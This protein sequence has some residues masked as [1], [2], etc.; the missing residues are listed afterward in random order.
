MST[1]TAERTVSARTHAWTHLSLVDVVC[2]V[3]TAAMLVSFVL[4][5]WLIEASASITGLSLLLSG[6]PPMTAE[7]S[8]AQ[9]EIRWALLL[10]P[11]GALI[12]AVG[13]G[14]RFSR[15]SS[16]RWLDRLVPLGA[17]VSFAYFAVYFIHDRQI[18]PQLMQYT[19][20][21]FWVAGF[22]SGILFLQHFAARSTA[23]VH[24]APT[25]TGL[26]ERL[27]RLFGRVLDSPRAGRII[28]STFRLQSLFG[29]FIVIVLAI[30]FS[31]V[32]DD[33]ILFLSQRNLS[34]VARD[35]SET[36]ILAVGM[37][38]VIIVGGIDL[39]VGSVVALAA[40]GVAYLLMRDL[41][42]AYAAIA[43]ILALGLFIGWWNGYVSERFRVPAFVTT[44][45]M[46]SIARGLAVI[47]SNRIAVPLSYGEGG[48]DPMF[49]TIG[50][51][52]TASSRCR[53][54]SWSASP[55]PWPLSCATRPS[56]AI[57]TP[58]AAI[59]RRRASPAWRSC[60][61]RSPP[62][63][64]V[65]SSRRWPASSMP[66]SSIRAVPMRRST[67]SST[68]SRRSSSAVPAWP[69][70]RAPSRVP[71][72]APSSSASSTTCLA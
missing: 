44:L 33:S 15:R 1:E 57:S 22:A 46:M 36:G 29:L 52:S 19:G 72:Q 71:S 56:A 62:S 70:A 65:R 11:L 13:L 5:P 45:G 66:R 16:Q 28:R 17:L 31:P 63:C 50:F 2:L 21:G 24:A 67:T 40:T 20:V 34:N 9:A 4:L 7:V 64:S 47:W 23:S 35:V 18:A 12:A 3:S 42:P 55:S 49:E 32:R 48:A 27:H 14:L 58:S 8:A 43:I 37:L 53:P 26:T 38:L 6:S 59:R 39:S 25:R 51:A 69:G 30:I 60:A 41:V 68:P 54:S 10:V 61:S